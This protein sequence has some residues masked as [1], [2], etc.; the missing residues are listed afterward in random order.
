MG[1]WY[2]FEAEESLGPLTAVGRVAVGAGLFLVVVAGLCF[3]ASLAQGT[4]RSAMWWLWFVTG[5]F[6]ICVMGSI[7][8]AIGVLVRAVDRAA[9]A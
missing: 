5:A 8:L 7:L 9:S 4:T 2:S 1:K 3:L 6:S